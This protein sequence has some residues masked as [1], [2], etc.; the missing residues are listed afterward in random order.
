MFDVCT[1]LACRQAA[2][3][4]GKS[5]RGGALFVIM[6]H[7]LCQA[8]VLLFLFLL[9]HIP[10]TS[11]CHPTQLS[12]YTP[13]TLPPQREP[14]RREPAPAL[15]RPR[16]QLAHSAGKTKSVKPVKKQ[17]IS[18]S[19][20]STTTLPP[21]TTTTQ[22]QQVQGANAFWPP[23]GVIQ[24]CQS[25]RV[26]AT[27]TLRFNPTTVMEDRSHLMG[28]LRLLETFVGVRMA[29]FGQYFDTPRQALVVV[30]EAVGLRGNGSI[31][32]G[33]TVGHL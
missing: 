18:D 13:P 10:T 7:R 22:L 31:I 15:P 27:T 17:A 4:G 20:P 6:M 11:A 25:A 5:R 30:G 23:G 2:C 9:H 8:L 28:R 33:T 19:Q 26:L 1:A 3:Y 29:S 24:A 14:I 12:L 32:I 21:T 16:P